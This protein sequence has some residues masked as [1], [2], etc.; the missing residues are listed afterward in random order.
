MYTLYNMASL[1][2]R[3]TPARKTRRD[4]SFD[5]VA[6]EEGECEC[7]DVCERADVHQYHAGAPYWY[8]GEEE[9]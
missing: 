4:D 9:R 1:T 5:R 3:M 6:E 8:T 7:D 2:W